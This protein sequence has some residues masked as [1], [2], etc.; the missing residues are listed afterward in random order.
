MGQ[1]GRLYDELGAFGLFSWSF[2][3]IFSHNRLVEQTRDRRPNAT[4]GHTDP[5]IEMRGRMHL[6]KA[7]YTA[8]LSRAIG[9]D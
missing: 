4:D 1:F 8:E 6:N 5:L 7:G 3:T 9:K 2:P